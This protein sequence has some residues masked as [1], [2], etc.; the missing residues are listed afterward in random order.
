M[1]V[2]RDVVVVVV[3]VDDDTIM[4]KALVLR[5]FVA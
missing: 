4:T 2:D 5:V 3:K 1:P